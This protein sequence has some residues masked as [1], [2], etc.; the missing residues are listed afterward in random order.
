MLACAL[1]V[2]GMLGGGNEVI[3]GCFW[4]GSGI[5]GPARLQQQQKSRP[6]HERFFYSFY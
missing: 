4:W 5:R 3:L 1:A 2:A 6:I